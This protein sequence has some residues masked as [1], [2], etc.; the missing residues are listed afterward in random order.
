M[1]DAA[2]PGLLAPCFS[3]IEQLLQEPPPLFHTLEACAQDDAAELAEALLTDLVRN[4]EAADKK[5]RLRSLRDLA[6]AALLLRDMGRL[7]MADD[8]LPLDRWR[9][10]LFERLPRAD[11]E[12]AMAEVDAIAKP[13]DTRPYGELL[14]Q[15]RRAR[16]LFFNIATRLETGASPGGGDLHAAI[17]YLKGIDDWP[18]A[19]M[20][21][22]PTAAVPKAW[23]A[24]VLD[25]ACL[26]RR[27]SRPRSQSLWSHLQNCGGA[28]NFRPE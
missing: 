27:R 23:R 12:A 22:A 6:E 15:W 9:D 24:H 26:G 10:A 5:A 2:E 4:A 17:Q 28:R 14:R 19:S 8:E 1:L 11:L 18:Q 21:D 20:R 7:V 16:R 3:R 13:D 25:R